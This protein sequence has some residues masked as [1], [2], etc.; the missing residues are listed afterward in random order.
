MGKVIRNFCWHKNFVP[1]GLSVPALG[2]YTFIK[3]FKMCLKSYFKEI[4]LKLATNGQNDMG[5]LLTSMFV[6]K[7]LLMFVPKGLF[8]P[9]LGLYTCIKALKYIPGQVS[10]YR[11]AG[12]LVFKLATIG[13]SDQAFLLTSGFCPQRVVCPCPGAIYRGKTFKK[14][15]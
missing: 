15:V 3:S 11:T 2:L 9:A 14:C 12:P 6:P 1:K 8:A 7:G 5:F 13:Q 10:V 4:V